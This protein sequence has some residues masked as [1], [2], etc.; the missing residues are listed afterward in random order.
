MR[1]HLPHWP[2]L[3]WLRLDRTWLTA[4]VAIASALVLLAG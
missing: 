4:L 2:A 3:H 1:I